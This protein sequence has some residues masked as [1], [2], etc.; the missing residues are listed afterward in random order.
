MNSSILPEIVEGGSI[1]DASLLALREQE[2]SPAPPEQENLQ[3]EEGGEVV[4]ATPRDANA[5]S[6]TNAKAAMKLA[7]GLTVAVGLAL[8][9]HYAA[10]MYAL[11]LPVEQQANA[12]NAVEKANDSWLPALTALLGSASTY[13]FTQ[14]E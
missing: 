13:Y 1:I 14:R 8:L 10:L 9:L 11:S 5:V 2:V 4:D 3:V 12:I 7:L 6:R